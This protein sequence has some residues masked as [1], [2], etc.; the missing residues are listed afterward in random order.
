MKSEPVPWI[1][2]LIWIAV[3]AIGCWFAI[4]TTQIH[5][6]LTLLLPS[7][8][9][10]VQRLLVKHISEG[11]TSRLII[12]GLKG[13]SSK[14][15]AEASIK[16]ASIM[17]ESAY[18]TY[19]R[20]GFDSQSMTD[21]KL[22]YDYRY[23]LSPTVRPG[24]FKGPELRMALTHRLQDLT[25]P[26]PPFIKNRIPN[27]PTGEFFTILKTWTHSKS[28][29]RLHGVWFSSDRHYALL[30]AETKA[31]GFDLDAQEQIQRNIADAV[32]RINQEHQPNS[33]VQL[34]QTGPS[35]F[36]VE[37]RAAIKKEAQWLSFLATALVIG[38]LFAC[39]RSVTLVGLSVVPLASGLLAGLIV[40]N[41]VYGFIH[42]ITLAFGT[43]LIGVAI[44]YPIHVF[45]QLLPHA[46]A[47]GI[48]RRI[49][50]IMRLGA[51]T[52]AVGYGAM[53]FSGFPG[54]SQL[55]LF[56]I[57]GLV[58]AAIVTK[59]VLPSLIPRG[60]NVAPLRKGL[61]DRLDILSKFSFVLP[62]VMMISLGYLMWSDKPFWEKDLAN[63]S[64]ISQ[65]SK[66]LDFRLR[67][68]LGAPDV[69]DVIVLTAPTEQEIL[70]QSEKLMPTL[71]QLV[72]HQTLTRYDM[73]A[74][75]L[76]SVRMQ[77]RRQSALPNPQVLEKQLNQAR[78]GLPFK[79]GTFLPFMQDVA[80]GKN[81]EPLTSQKLQGTVLGTKIHSLLFQE[82]GQWVGMV[83]LQGV[84]D[85]TQLN[86]LSL[87]PNEGDLF[88]LDLKQESNHMVTTYREEM[89]KFLGLGVIA[90]MV[91]LAV[92]LRSS[93]AFLRVLFPVATTA[94]T[95][96]AVLHSIDERLSL[97]HIAS[98]L[99]VVGIGLDY[100]LFF[101]RDHE[102][103][104][105]RVQTIFAVLVCSMTTILVF[106]LLALS[107][108]PVLHS[109]GSTAA[110]G[111]FCCLL[112]SSISRNQS[113]PPTSQP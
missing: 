31:A 4:T 16:L 89:M 32:S 75:Y 33:G 106:G 61:I 12:I 28:P 67:T 15:L 65:N 109:I 93:K 94:L 9:S 3:F 102:S 14:I 70:E 79:A 95:V 52:T 58:T 27:D 20:N 10:P 22:L 111:A 35:V 23:L 59:W 88:Y 71:D 5:T 98:M 78:D 36:A 92:A 37:S 86:A 69:R 54:L 46:S 87:E 25:A 45:S 108:T 24:R 112:F 42:G 56:A 44:D 18:F 17:R 51:V 57:V 97:F 85:R 110:L 34:V 91:I 40:V 74:R 6:Q 49:W 62:V 53:L 80:A 113:R 7:D 90:I 64:P 48:V 66:Q 63:L 13:R 83:T 11:S 55:G 76:P 72:R 104:A 8:G 19:V 101:N 38:F 105:E 26:L 84:T 41:S 100:A 39:Y 1:P 2:A 29:E 81:L 50:P 103:E 21:Y 68:E 82:E 47:S 96:I 43:T 60:S 99:L 107:Q 30:V 77:H 73:A